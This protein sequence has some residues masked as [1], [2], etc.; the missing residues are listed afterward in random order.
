MDDEDV[1]TLLPR[2]HRASHKW[3]TAVAVVAGSPGMEGASALCAR[4]AAHAGAGMVRL[5]VPGSS[6]GAGGTRPG[7]WPLEAVRMPLEAAGWADDVLGVLARCAALVIGPGL[8]RDEATRS[9]VRRLIGRSAVPV[10]ADADALAA[11][12]AADSAPSA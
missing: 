4:G 12:G 7:P 11:L 2:R 6:D 8:G 3:Q 10:V 9:E 1:A 5:A